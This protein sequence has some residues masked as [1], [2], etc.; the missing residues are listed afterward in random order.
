MC[1]SVWEYFSSIGSNL[2]YT[3]HNHNEWTIK[4]TSSKYNSYDEEGG[5]DEYDDYCDE[6]EG[7]QRSDVDC[8][9]DTNFDEDDYGG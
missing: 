6:S 7:C 8:I 1:S 4:H 5:C 2:I 9:D 3:T